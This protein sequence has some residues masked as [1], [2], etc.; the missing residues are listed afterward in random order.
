MSVGGVSSAEDRKSKGKRV[1]AQLSK[2]LSAGADAGL[3]RRRARLGTPAARAAIDRSRL[4]HT[5]LT[6]RQALRVSSSAFEDEMTEPVFDG[7]TPQPG[8]E[9]VD[10]FSPR[11]VRVRDEET[12]STMLMSSTLP[13]TTPGSGGPVDLSLE[14]RGDGYVT[15]NSLSDVRL[16]SEYTAAELL[17]TR[18][19]VNVAEASPTASVLRDGRLFYPNAFADI[20][21]VATPKPTGVEFGFVVRSAAATE[22]ID[23]ETG[24]DSLSFAFR[25]PEG[26]RFEDGPREYVIVRDEEIVAYVERPVAY[27]ADG[28]TVQTSYSIR[29]D[30][31]LRLH[32]EHRDADV[33]FPLFVDPEISSGFGTGDWAGWTSFS[34]GNFAAGFAPNGGLRLWAATNA[35]FTNG[36][37]A[38]WQLKSPAG[39]AIY[40]ASFGGLGNDSGNCFYY[41]PPHKCTRLA[42]GIAYAGGGF[43]SPVLQQS[44][45]Y[46]YPSATFCAT[47]GLPCTKALAKGTFERNV[48]GVYIQAT[49]PAGGAQTSTGNDQGFVTADYAFLY[50]V[51]FDRPTIATSPIDPGQT[52]WRRTAA[53]TVSVLML[54][55]GAGL[56][57]DGAITFDGQGSAQ[58][59][60]IPDVRC[61]PELDIFQCETSKS[62][63]L[64][65]SA[66]EGTT[67]HTLAAEDQY[68][69]VATPQ[70]WQDKVDL[71]N[72]SVSYAGPADGSTVT[73]PASVSVSATDAL[74]G[75]NG[76]KVRVRKPD[77]SYVAPDPV[78]VACSASPCARSLTF[79]PSAGKG[80]YKIETSAT[81][82]AGNAGTKTVSIHN[83]VVPGAPS[84]VSGLPGDK[85]I[86]ASWTAPSD[87]GGSAITGYVAKAYLESAPNGAAQGT[88]ATTG[89]GVTSGTIAGLSNGTEYVVKVA[90]KNAAGTGPESAPS[91]AVTPR[92]VPGAPT[93]V[94]ATRANG[95]AVVSW[96]APAS[97][98]GSAITGY[99]VKAHLASAPNGA[100]VA[101]ASTTGATTVTVGGLTN[102]T[103]HGFKVA[104]SNTAG[105]GPESAASNA[106]TPAGPPLEPVLNE[107]VPGTGQF[108][109]SW[110]APNANGSPIT[111]YTLT[112]EERVGRRHADACRQRHLGHRRQSR[113]WHVRSDAGREERR[114]R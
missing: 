78:D 55:S 103:A 113:P 37:L 66:A 46:I 97:N 6:D 63:N 93:G 73:A 71:T 33:R 27:D 72:P 44:E 75:L 57:D 98:G 86:A 2:E 8:W 40:K 28:R 91:G 60:Q 112:T 21:A 68:G 19:T 23:L 99:A 85:K 38:G 106:V 35:T 74:S 36:A 54:D 17:E 107:P 32:V 16:D 51:D 9:V 4:L 10:R 13:L 49:S 41:G 50:Y 34:E 111:G 11:W 105:A 58:N 87:D 95:A 84:A 79:T 62:F 108:T 56:A 104:A 52:G 47:G 67:S 109:V 25:R 64:T 7:G 30:G 61:I 89:A 24:D 12:G 110:S 45:T 101:S 77:G 83:A 20:D 88:A 14:R 100:P 65:Y 76:L 5:G 114:G 102:G 22:A 1:T 94:T 53:R 15:R 69:N 31:A 59:S 3:A 43:S 92:T 48:A 80:L 18:V 82:V 70:T 90:A 29:P 26:E 39:T 96:T 42:A 81:D